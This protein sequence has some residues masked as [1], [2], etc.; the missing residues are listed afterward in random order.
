MTK[1]WWPSGHEKLQPTERGVWMENQLAVRRRWRMAQQLEEYGSR[2]LDCLFPRQ[3]NLLEILAVLE[4]SEINRIGSVLIPLFRVD[5]IPAA[6]DVAISS[7]D[8][9]ASGQTRDNYT[10]LTDALHTRHIAAV[11]DCASAAATYHMSPAEVRHLQGYCSQQ[12]KWLALQ[13]LAALTPVVPIE[14]FMMAAHARGW[15]NKERYRFAATTR[16]ALV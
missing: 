1:L 15:G 2:E 13:P 16:A 8:E 6:A 10:E 5:L 12:L 11:R 14:Y 9:P 7:L 4:E 3:R